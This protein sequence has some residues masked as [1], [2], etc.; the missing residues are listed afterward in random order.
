MPKLLLE[1]SERLLLAEIENRPAVQLIGEYVHDDVLI[2]AD[3]PYVWETRS[4]RQSGR[5][6]YFEEMTDADH[7]ELLDA[8]DHHP[9]PVL[10]SGYACPLYDDRL[11]HWTRKTCK[12]QAEKGKERTEILWLNPVAAEAAIAVPLFK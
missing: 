11:K 1:T 10:L 6:M 4:D 9:G 7:I 12:A 3:P 2:Y 8:L 5:K